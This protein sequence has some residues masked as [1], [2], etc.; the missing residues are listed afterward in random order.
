[1]TGGVTVVI[2]GF[3]AACLLAGSAWALAYVRANA[4][5]PR[6]QR[7]AA[8]MADDGDAPGIEIAQSVFRTERKRAWLW[9]RIEA[10]YPLLQG[11][12]AAGIAGGV[13]A[14]VGVGLWLVMQLILQIPGGP[15]LALGILGG[16][17]ASGYGTL[18]WL[19]ARE[20]KK[21]TQQ[22]PD[23]VDQIVQLSR[24]G[25]PPL[26]ALSNVVPDIPPPIQGVLE[27]VRSGLAAGL[28]ADRTMRTVAARVRIPEFTLFCAVLRLQRRA[29]GGVS[30][31]LGNLT[32]ALRERR[33]TALKA[34]SSTAQTRLT[35]VVLILLPIVVLAMQK[36]TAP[37]TVDILFNTP[38]G[39][40]VLRIGIGL[41]VLGVGVAYLLIARG[42]R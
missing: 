11:P 39:L 40:F 25:M 41:I 28:D 24:T 7:V 5:K 6:I 34:H 18:V 37:E 36:F 8:P 15:W 19:Q 2:A 42:T 17:V 33:K 30:E 12:R 4:L 32:G 35:L 13:A 1:M 31:A 23:V 20:T 38:N 29:G 10:W 26:E 27:A 14:G 3:L 16:M 22:F 9:D 21:F